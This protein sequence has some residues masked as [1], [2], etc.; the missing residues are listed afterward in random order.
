MRIYLDLVAVLNFLVDGL[1]LLG[2]NRLCGFP[3]GI[4]RCALASA[5]GSVYAAG[6]MLPGFGFLGNTF[7]RLVCLAAMGV[8]AFGWS[9]SAL[10]RTLV[11]VLLAMAL[12]GIALG[13]GGGSFAALLLGAVLVWL[14]CT[15]GF[16]GG[17]G[18][19]SF[20]AVRLSYRGKTMELTALR[21]TGNTLRDPVSGEAVL[22]LGAD[23]AKNLVGLDSGMLASPVETLVSRKIPGLRLLPYRT[24]GQGNGMLLAL[25]LD[26]VRIDGKP[27]G[28]LVAF[29]PRGLDSEGSYQALAG[30]M[31]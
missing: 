19:R 30:G 17:I 3:P 25:R 20:A 11:F 14:L 22:V 1:L 12:G 29:A 2:T 26:S 5:V 16:R 4:K 6:C 18:Q 27:A 24:V 23:A 15:A 10:R 7:W 31:A 9:I 13:I 21:D 8:I 28:T